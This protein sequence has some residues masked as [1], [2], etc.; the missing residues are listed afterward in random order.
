MRKLCS[1]AMIVLARDLD[2]VRAYHRALE[3]AFSVADEVVVVV[4]DRTPADLMGWF[5]QYDPDG[6][7][8]RAERR[9]FAN[10]SDQ[11]NY[12]A[13]LCRY[14]WAIVLDADA[15][16]EGGRELAAEIASAPEDVDMILAHIVAVDAAGRER[17]RL[18]WPVAYRRARCSW[19]YRGHNQ[20][21]GA[22]A[23]AQSRCT[24]R[25]I[26]RDEDAAA[27]AKRTIP[28]LMED[29]AEDPN[30]P[31]APFFLSRAHWMAGDLTAAAS[32]ARRSVDL[33][34][35]GVGFSTAWP[36]L[37]WATL[38]LD[39]VVAA[40]RVVDE[41][42]RRHPTMPDL[43]DL[44]AFVCKARQMDAIQ[45]PSNAYAITEQSSPKFLP[46][47]LEIAQSIGW[48]LAATEPAHA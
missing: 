29:H 35:D 6:P 40:E 28:L 16:L 36:L 47:F 23:W 46:R 33:A 41:G 20:L 37:A 3:S 10:F 19:K 42:L 7:T 24:I 12:A 34:P 32:W 9:A 11:R 45:D 22:R 18:S 14:E 15:I 13:S 43:L 38:D 4:D 26:Y 48:P 25:S 8:L 2:A 31:H 5:R 21:Q 1:L 17:T 39:G 30:D 44:K 27:R